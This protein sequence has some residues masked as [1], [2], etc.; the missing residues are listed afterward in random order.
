MLI[1]MSRNVRAICKRYRMNR[2]SISC[3]TVL[4][5]ERRHQK[6]ISTDD[7]A[8]GIDEKSRVLFVAPFC[9]REFTYHLRSFLLPPPRPTFILSYN[10]NRLRHYFPFFSTFALEH[11]FP[12]SHLFVS[13]RVERNT[14]SQA[15]YQPTTDTTS[16]PRRNEQIRKQ[17]LFLFQ[18]HLLPMH[19]LRAEITLSHFSG[20]VWWRRA[21]PII[22]EWTIRIY[23]IFF[24]WNKIQK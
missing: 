24:F 5:L 12:P 10:V 4:V 23:L 8:E 21:E 11:I 16:V 20:S 9:D 14:H 13:A 22:K 1:S 19:K 15:S 18:Y 6:W 2:E 3:R 17:I 7:D